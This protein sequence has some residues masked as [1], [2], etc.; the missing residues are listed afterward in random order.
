MK[1]VYYFNTSQVRKK[2][3][4]QQLREREIDHSHNSLQKRFEIF[5]SLAE[6]FVLTDLP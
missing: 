5:T 3:L 4:D 1:Y 6:T 2:I